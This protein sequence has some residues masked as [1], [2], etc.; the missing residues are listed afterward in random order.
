MFN[1]DNI[2]KFYKQ[3]NKHKP[4][5]YTL[6]GIL[7]IFGSIQV[8]RFVQEIRLEPVKISLV[9]TLNSNSISIPNDLESYPLD[10]QILML[11]EII[12]ARNDI[13][14]I[15]TLIA[16]EEAYKK[17]KEFKRQESIKRE[18]ERLK[19]EKA[20]LEADIKRVQSLIIDFKHKDMMNRV[21]IPQNE[22]PFAYY[23]ILRESAW[24]TNAGSINA[25][26]GLCQSSPGKK[27]SS[28]GSD[29]KTNPITQLKWCNGYALNK[30]GSW[31]EAYVFWRNNL[32][33]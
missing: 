30:Y 33:F 2:N 13:D 12:K 28:S 9:N 18:K 23:I 10:Q 17:S 4:F 8:Q 3:F 1:K 24:K 25:G 6:I 31:K 7:L 16:R 20:E 22:Q 21:G 14:T 27:M 29:W 5:N 11:E 15:H 26:Y 32:S 19:R